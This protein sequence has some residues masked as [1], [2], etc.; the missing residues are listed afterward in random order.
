MSTT[1]RTTR[2]RCG[3]AAPSFP[4]SSVVTKNGKFGSTKGPTRSCCS[5]A[6]PGRD[7]AMTAPTA[8]AAP[9]RAPLSERRTRIVTRGSPAHHRHGLRGAPR[10]PALTILAREPAIRLR[11][12]RHLHLGAVVEDL[13][14]LTRAQCDDAEEHRLGELCR[15]LEWRAHRALALARVGPVGL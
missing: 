7:S 6:V 12:V 5:R 8:R 2:F 13:L 15:I 4:A 11:H 1:Q 10:L 9:Q 3:N 14:R